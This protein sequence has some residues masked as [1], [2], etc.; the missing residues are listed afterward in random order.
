[1]QVRLTDAVNLT[2]KCDDGLIHAGLI[3]ANIHMRTFPY[4]KSLRPLFQPVR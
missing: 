1:M 3:L 2:R 4:G